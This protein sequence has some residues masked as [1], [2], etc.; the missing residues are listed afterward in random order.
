MRSPSPVRREGA[1]EPE[2]SG[3]GCGPS[4]ANLPALPRG[5]HP[6]PWEARSRRAWLLRARG[7]SP[8]RAFHFLF[9]SGASFNFV[10]GVPE[11]AGLCQRSGRP[12]PG[13]GGAPKVGGGRPRAGTGARLAR[14]VLPSASCALPVAGARHMEAA[15][16]LTPGPGARA[17]SPERRAPRC[18]RLADLRRELGAL[19]FLAGPAVSRGPHRGLVPGAGVPGRRASRRRWAGARGATVPGAWRR[20]GPGA[21]ACARAALAALCGWTAREW[22]RPRPVSRSG[23]FSGGGLPRSRRKP[24][25][26]QNTAENTEN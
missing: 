8:R 5:F 10:F 17:L 7:P 20:A 19:L 1:P 4:V 6:K 15:E 25:E 18:L 3:C 21:F 26:P 22:D 2:V 13:G 12:G 24:P 23:A 9:L 11:L 14:P 16:E